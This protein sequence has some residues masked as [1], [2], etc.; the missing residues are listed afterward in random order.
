[1]MCE[2]IQSLANQG[3]SSKLQHLKFLLGF[4]Y[5]GTVDWVIGH[6][7]ELN[8]QLLLFQA[9]QAETLWAIFKFAIMTD[10]ME[11]RCVCP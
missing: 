6:M 5:L 4:H 8:F 10:V 3:S 11:L 9:D 1:M 7:F 2:D